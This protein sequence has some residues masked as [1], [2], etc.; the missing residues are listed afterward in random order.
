[1]KSLLH[2]IDSSV[3]INE[4]YFGLLSLSGQWLWTNRCYH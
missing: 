1:M 2:V 4:S 3:S